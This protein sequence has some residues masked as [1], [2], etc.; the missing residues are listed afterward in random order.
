MTNLT[1]PI[2]E[3]ILNDSYLK[4]YNHLKSNFT[5]MCYGWSFYEMCVFVAIGNPRWTSSQN[6]FLT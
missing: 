1:W 3:N 4:P 2:W 5:E 6:M